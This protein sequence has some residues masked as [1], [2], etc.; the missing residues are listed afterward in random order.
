MCSVHGV[1]PEVDLQW[2]TFHESDTGMIS[3]HD[4]TIKVT[5]NGETFD[6]MLTSKY[7]LLN[8]KKQ[9]L[10][11]MCKASSWIVNNFDRSTKFDL[12]FREGTF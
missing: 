10:T 6:V 2:R 11:L 4:E 9:R 5:T 1:R 12:L 7:E 3:F 8:A